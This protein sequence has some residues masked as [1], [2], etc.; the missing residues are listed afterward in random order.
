MREY[1]E[2]RDIPMLWGDEKAAGAGGLSGDD[3]KGER[4]G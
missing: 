3:R 2:S 4:Y 1:P